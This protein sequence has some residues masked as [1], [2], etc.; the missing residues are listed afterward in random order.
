VH[1]RWLR[2]PDPDS[3]KSGEN[4]MG[5]EADSSILTHPSDLDGMAWLR[6]GRDLRKEGP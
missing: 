1:E 4:A 2:N 6:D 5:D 3:M